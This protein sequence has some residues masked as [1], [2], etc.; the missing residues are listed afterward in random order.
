M[1]RRKKNIGSAGKETLDRSSVSVGHAKEAKRKRAQP[2]KF[3]NYVFKVL[4]Q[5]HPQVS[6]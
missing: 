6:D 2:A 5:V 3:S 4:K 1:G